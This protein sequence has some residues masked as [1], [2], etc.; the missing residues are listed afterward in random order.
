TG[1][2]NTPTF[3]SRQIMTNINMKDGDIIVLSGL[4]ESKDS[5][6]S[7][8]LSFLPKSWSTKSGQKMNTDL[9]IVL[10]AK[11]VVV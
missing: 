3:T 1:V 11:K 9:L 4:A 10:Q 6:T 5:T 2:N 8:G 7:T